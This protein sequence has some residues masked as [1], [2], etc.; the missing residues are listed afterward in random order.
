MICGE[1]ANTTSVSNAPSLNVLDLSRGHI[2]I[3]PVK[4]INEGH[5]VPIFL[6]SKAYDSIMVFL[7]QLNRAMFPSYVQKSESDEKKE[8]HTWDLGSSEV[9]FSET[10]LRLRLL[11]EVLSRIID[12]V[13]PDTGPRRFGNASFRKWYQIIEEQS[14]NLLSQYLPNS[15]LEYASQSS[16][17]ASPQDEMSSY[18]L[19][20]FG[21][22]QR[23][24][25]GSG[26][27]LSFLAFLGCIWKLGGFNTSDSGN[28]E[29]GI[30]LGIID[31]YLN[32]IRRLI[33][34][35]TL[36][37]AGSHG[38]W[39]L[40][41]HSFI[42]YI[43]G[44]A[45]Y[46]P[47]I[48]PE[49]QTPTE[50][51]REGA[52]K[53]ADVA[54]KMTVD[55]ERNTNLYFGAIGFICD[56]KKGPFWEHSPMLYDISG[57]QAG[58]GKINKVSLNPISPRKRSLIDPRAC[59]KCTTQKSSQNSPSSNISVL[60]PSSAGSKIQTPHHHQLPSMHPASPSETDLLYH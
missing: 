39:G 27:E 17:E 35:Y 5:D 6:T 29:R 16:P 55:R 13:P 46:G 53:P 23:L 33:K 32:L 8:M 52:P 50:G 43:L 25:Y 10:V 48:S 18:F 12:E 49:D 56:V 3:K 47:P 41:D 36:E 26:H 15:I 1:M 51:S 2:F 54:K 44:S 7:L 30:V 45:Q 9:V 59:L 42:P 40:D 28:E 20:S 21:S 11:L 57:V 60:A 37:P 34:T 31:P 24:D 14:T 22:A 58:W 19:G 4:K 38:V